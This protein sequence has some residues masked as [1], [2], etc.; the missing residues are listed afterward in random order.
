MG[1]QP[2]VGDTGLASVMALCHV[3]DCACVL[4]PPAVL[5]PVTPCCCL[6][7]SMQGIVKQFFNEKEVTSTLVMDALFCGCKQLDKLS[8]SKVCG[9]AADS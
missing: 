1:A 9:G 6:P 8:R 3:P 5:F 2:A 7:L 4:L